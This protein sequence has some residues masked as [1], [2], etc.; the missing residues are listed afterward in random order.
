MALERLK[1]AD[2]EWDRIAS[3]IYETYQNAC[4]IQIDIV[5]S[6]PTGYEKRRGNSEIKEMF[7]GTKDKFVRN[8]LKEGLKSEYNRISA[9]GK[10]TYFSPYIKTSLLSYTNTGKDGLSYVFLCDIIMSDTEGGGHIYVCPRDDSFLIKYLI[11]FHKNA[12]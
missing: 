12:K 7:H 1:M 8:I 10:G 3:M 2:P 11:R 9:L 6:D 5:H 4:I